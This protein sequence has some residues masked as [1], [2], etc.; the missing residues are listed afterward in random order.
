MGSGQTYRLITI[1]VALIFVALL[2]CGCIEHRFMYKFDRQGVCDFSYQARGDSL[3]IYEPEGSYPASPLFLVQTSTE[4]DS[5]GN[6][7][8]ILEAQTRIWGDSLPRTLGLKEVPFAEVFLKHPGELTRTPLFF[9]TF[10]NFECRFEG[11][12]RSELEGDRWEF[13][14]EECRRLESGEDST[15]SNDERQILEEK[16]AAGMLLWN[17]ERYKLRTREILETS[18]ANRPEADL[19]QQWVDSALV[20][21]DSLIDAYASSI[22][23]IDLDL[24]NLEWW[25][26]LEP[27]IN[28]VLT[29]NLNMIGDTILHG[30]IVYVSEL[31]EMRHQVTEDLMDESFEV[32]ADL[33][34]RVI[35]DNSMAMEVGVLIWK[36]NGEDLADNDVLMRATSLYLFPGR[37]AGVLVLALAIFLAVKLRKPKTA[38][39]VETPEEPPQTHENPPPMGHG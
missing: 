24:V 26:E 12:R 36:F 35:N 2:Y 13:I 25:D 30:E 27:R 20:E 18:L 16:Y 29:E 21:A 34:G 6:E 15:L 14:P 39:E 1:S 31:L 3:D 32:R 23:V 28:Q 9:M 38:M 7:T 37:I 17:R 8:H 33:P 11:R 4:I 5:S 10:Y 22:A 19:P